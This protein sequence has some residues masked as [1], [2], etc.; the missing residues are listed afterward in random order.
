MDH[1]IPRLRRIH[2][3]SNQVTKV[4]LAVPAGDV[5]EVSE[6]VAGQLLARSTQFKDVTPVKPPAA[7]KAAAVKKAAK[8]ATV[9]AD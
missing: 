8:K 2:H 5:L 1:P 7:K 4:G 9:E 6:S 3:D